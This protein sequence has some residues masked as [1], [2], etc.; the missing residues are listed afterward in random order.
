MRIVIDISDQAQGARIT[1]EGATPAAAG[2]QPIGASD[3]AAM[4]GQ[5]INAGPAPSRGAT[6]L[7]DAEPA[8]MPYPSDVG[9]ADA[10]SGGAAPS[11]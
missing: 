8:V 11:A 5:G 4:Q 10:Q 2:F 6:A 1:T 7:S 9:Q 3:L